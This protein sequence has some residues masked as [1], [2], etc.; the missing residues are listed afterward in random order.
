[1]ARKFLFLQGP[2]TPFFSRLGDAL[3]NAGEG[4]FRVNFCAGDAL[5]W[6]GKPAWDYRGEARG[7]GEWLERRIAQHALTDLV[8]FGDQRPLHRAAAAI[9]RERRLRVHAFEE[10]YV[11]PNWITF[12]R[13]GVNA[14]S[15]LPREAR[16]YF[17]ANAA[18]PD[19]GEGLRVAPSIRSRAAH[20]M[21]YHAANLAN[22]LAFPGYRTH[23]QRLA[24]TEYAGWALRYA[25]FPYWQRRDHARIEALLGRGE[26][27]YFMPLQLNGDAQIVRHSPFGD[28][29]SALR[30]VLRSFARHAPRE[31]R[32][33]LK[34][35]P[36]DPGLV[37]HAGRIERLAAE[38]GVSDRVTF[39][40]TGSLPRLLDHALGVVVVNSTVGFSAL[41]HGRPLK[42]LGKAIYDLPGMTFQGSLDDFWGRLPTPDLALVR[43]FRNVVIHATQVNGGFY[44]PH[45]M[46]T[47][48]A[49]CARL[50]EPRSR[51]EQLLAAFPARRGAAT[52]AS[53]LALPAPAELA[54][55]V[56][57]AA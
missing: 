26:P 12:E 43:A 47:A 45:G 10:G 7:F 16:W 44:C 32:L 51:L 28:M 22:P 39:L 1:V 19:A 15:A 4:V 3:R 38:L 57:Q 52:P 8:L 56:E 21:A 41:Q 25:R 24:S 29:A 5:Y 6:R 50:L 20:D 48:I 34:N 35:H 14:A 2:S 9:A 27:F 40:E 46:A 17:Q 23:R 42:T 30:P 13:G 18:L 36:L 54:E 37:P 31:T 49:G 33:V 53:D 55:G 11:R